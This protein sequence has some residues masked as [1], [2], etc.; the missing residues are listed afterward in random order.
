MC[1][2]EGK[3]GEVGERPWK[4]IPRRRD[5]RVRVVLAGSRRADGSRGFGWLTSTGIREGRLVTVRILTPDS[6]ISSGSELS[7]DPSRVEL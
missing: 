2:L 3:V 7:I 4:A 1:E 6:D 5:G